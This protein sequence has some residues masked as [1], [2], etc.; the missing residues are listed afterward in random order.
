MTLTLPVAT[1]GSHGCEPRLCRQHGGLFPA[2]V[3]IRRVD[4]EAREAQCGAWIGSLAL[5]SS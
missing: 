1:T 3:V 5:L 2:Y 4:S